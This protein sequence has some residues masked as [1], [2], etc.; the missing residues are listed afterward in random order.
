[1]N[2][3]N[4]IENPLIGISIA[5]VSAFVVYFFYNKY[6][7]IKRRLIYRGK[8]DRL[9]REAERHGNVY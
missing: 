3:E 2:V 7:K 8:L 1:M 5:L 4:L 6:R 9:L